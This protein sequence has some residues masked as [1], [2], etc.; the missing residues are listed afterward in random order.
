MRAPSTLHDSTPIP[1]APPPS[2]SVAERELVRLGWLQV[3]RDPPRFVAAL[4][5]TLAE[6]LPVLVVLVGG[7]FAC[8]A[9]VGRLAYMIDVAVRHL[10]RLLATTNGQRVTLPSSDVVGSAVLDALA[11]CLEQRTLPPATRAAWGH[12]WAVMCASLRAPTSVEVTPGTGAHA[13]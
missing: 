2:L 5:A 1:G 9:S 6:R 8:D 11:T 3:Q 10:D 12:V 7:A 4:R 13:A